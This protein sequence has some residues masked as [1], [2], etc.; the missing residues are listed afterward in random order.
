MWV[1]SLARLFT[2]LL[3][4]SCTVLHFILEPQERSWQDT[5]PPSA[6]QFLSLSDPCKPV[7]VYAFVKIT[8][9]FW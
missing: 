8:L 3:S 7:V 9:D 1:A 5:L 6:E 2:R 4:Y